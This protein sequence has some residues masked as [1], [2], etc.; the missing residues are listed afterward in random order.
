[1]DKGIY[2]HVLNNSKHCKGRYGVII[3]VLV[4]GVF[5]VAFFDGQNGIFHETKIERAIKK[6][7]V[8]A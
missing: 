8:L 2:V 6:Y 1:M 3:D 4:P 5:L 7:G